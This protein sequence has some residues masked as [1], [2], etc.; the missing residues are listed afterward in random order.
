MATSSTVIC[1]SGEDEVADLLLAACS[2]SPKSNCTARPSQA[3]Y[4]RDRVARRPNFSRSC[5][6]ELGADALA[7]QDDEDRVARRQPDQP[8]GDEGDEEQGR[9]GGQQATYGVA[10]MTAV[11][12]PAGRASAT[13]LRQPR[14]RRRDAADGYSV[15]QTSLKSEAQYHS[16]PISAPWTRLFTA[17]GQPGLVTEMSGESSAMM[18]LGLDEEPGALGLVDQ[19]VLLLQQRV[20][21]G[22]A[23]GRGVGATGHD[24]LRAEVG[25]QVARR[26]R[27]VRAPRAHE[28]V[29]VV[30]A[31]ELLRDVLLVRGLVGLDGDAQLGHGVDE[32]LGDALHEGVDS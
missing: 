8:E 32:R 26:I 23:V 9:D 24:V 4:W 31:A 17:S 28:D 5:I 22:V 13:R 7:A 6:D 21:V 1:E 25:A 15:T 11:P 30:V 16:G 29:V 20:D 14:T 2:D 12:L 27:E 19:R 10:A 18:R 3:T